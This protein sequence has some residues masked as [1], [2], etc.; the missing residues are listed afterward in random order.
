MRHYTLLILVLATLSSSSDSEEREEITIT[1]DNYDWIEFQWQGDS[2]NGR[3][4]EHAYMYI[5]ISLENLDYKFTAQFDLGAFTAIYGNSIE[6]YLTKHIDLRTKLDTT[7]KHIL[8]GM[9]CGE[10]VDLAIRQNGK[11]VKQFDVIHYAGY[12]ETL[13]TDSINSGT[14]KHIGTIGAD[15]CENKI[16]IIDYPNER[17][18]LVDSLSSVFLQVNFVDCKKDNNGRIILPLTIGKKDYFAMFDTGSSIFSIATNSNFWKENCD[19]SVI[20]TLGLQAWGET[21]MT[22]GSPLNK[23]VF[24]GITKM[25]KTTCYKIPA[26]DNYF[27]EEIGLI[28]NVWFKNQVVIVDFKTNR[29]GIV[30]K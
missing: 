26:Y 22:Y 28:G 29:F 9:E 30:D 24:I 14:V 17:L 2:A 5:P 19:T 8:D 4:F 12:G 1:V 21:I 20:D 6:P 10:F 7:S 3:Y 11:I 25:P 18:T 23:D 16:L 27:T 13:T 15:F